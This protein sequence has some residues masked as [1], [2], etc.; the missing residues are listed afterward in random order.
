MRCQVRRAN[1]RYAD[2]SPA[3]AA[4]PWLPGWCSQPVNRCTNFLCSADLALEVKGSVKHFAPA[5]LASRATRSVMAGAPE[6]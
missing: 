3:N 4:G 5:A 6:A 2:R 1:I